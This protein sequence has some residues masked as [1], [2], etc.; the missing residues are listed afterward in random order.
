MLLGISFSLF[1]VDLFKYPYGLLVTL[2][3]TVKRD[4]LVL[5]L[6]YLYIAKALTAAESVLLDVLCVHT[7][8]QIHKVLTAV[9]R[10]VADTLYSSRYNDGLQ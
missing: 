3:D 5:E 9:K 7:D 1:A 10:P 2:S 8:L 6:D 4:I